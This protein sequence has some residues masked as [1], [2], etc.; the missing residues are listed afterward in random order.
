MRKRCS[1]ILI[2][3]ILLAWSSAACTSNSKMVKRYTGGTPTLTPFANKA[4]YTSTR[5]PGGNPDEE[6]VTNPVFTSTIEPTYLEETSEVVI[7]GEPSTTPSPTITPGYYSPT[8]SAMG[9]TA[10]P[11]ATAKPAE[12][13][14]TT[15]SN[16]PSATTNPIQLFATAT[17]Y[18][19]SHT[20][21]QPAAT[22][23]PKPPTITS[24]P[25]ATLTPEGCSIT[26]NT[27]FENQVVNLINQERTD[28][29]LPAL[30][31]NSSLRL[32]A[33]R[34]SE[35]MACND[36]FNHTGSD[37]STLGSRLIA[38]GYSYS[39]AA[40]NIA[41]SS[42][43]N[44]SAQSV[45]SMWMNSPGHKANI[46]SENVTEIGVGFRFAGDSDTYDYDAYYTADF[47]LP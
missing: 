7:T 34:H 20:P 46:L 23:T 42:S 31:N 43:S 3:F 45:V 8:V 40:E 12:P 29:G 6:L 4:T 27:T 19:P 1:L 18:I 2:I 33:W 44:F 11:T 28:R 38:V 10:V 35:D 37:G 41:A 15:G 22:Y 25:P 26:G 9:T 16:E 5:T 21:N 13:S 24:I 30:G 14:S 32:A 47:G 36:F 39:W 17:L